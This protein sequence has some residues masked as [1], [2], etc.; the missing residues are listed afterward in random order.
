MYN[1]MQLSYF[2][3]TTPYLYV[4]L[5][6]NI[7][8]SSSFKD[9]LKN[10]IEE[11]FIVIANMNGLVIHISN[12]KFNK[13]IKTMID[14]TSVCDTDSFLEFGLDDMYLE[15]NGVQ[16][17]DNNGMLMFNQDVLKYLYQ[18]KLAAINQV[19]HETLL[20]LAVRINYIENKSPQSNAVSTSIDYLLKK[21][22]KPGQTNCKGFVEHYARTN[23]TTRRNR[24]KRS[25]SP[26]QSRIG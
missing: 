24:L 10:G 6:K 25:T 17:L 9:M 18:T 13:S 20:D 19:I 23:N 3:T 14:V 22:D 11:V 8:D 2:L 21:D 4:L 5:P 1:L 16:I 15:T 26:F 7:D 12:V